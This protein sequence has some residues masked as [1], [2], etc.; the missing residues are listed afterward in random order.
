MNDP[1]RDTIQDLRHRRRRPALGL[2][3]ETVMADYLASNTYRA[4]ANEAC[5]ASTGAS[6]RS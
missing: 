5:S 2:P 1:P 3:E 4:T 6:S